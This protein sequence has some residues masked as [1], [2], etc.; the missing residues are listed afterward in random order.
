VKC[1]EVLVP[2]HPLFLKEYLESMEEKK[3]QDI[4]SLRDRLSVLN[5]NKFRAC[6]FLVNFHTKRG[7]KVLV[8]SDD[9]YA[10]ETYATKMGLRNFISVFFNF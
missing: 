10:L 5:P 6:Q 9:I 7:D 4:K 1:S 8:F 3:T 2:M